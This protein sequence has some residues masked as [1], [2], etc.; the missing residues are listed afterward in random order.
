MSQFGFVDAKSLL[1]ALLCIWSESGVTSWSSHRSVSKIP[2][3]VKLME[4]NVAIRFSF[5]L[6]KRVGRSLEQNVLRVRCGETWQSSLWGN[7]LSK[8]CQQRFS[9]ENTK[10]NTVQPRN[11]CCSMRNKV[12]FSEILLLCWEMTW[13]V[14]NVST[15]CGIPESSTVI[16]GESVRLRCSS[17][18]MWPQQTA[19]VQN[20]FIMNYLYKYLCLFLQRHLSMM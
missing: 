12:K 20:D 4:V 19:L 13:D 10:K 9:Y 7:T 1:R 17:S 5:V 16:R 18:E 3:A 2:S 14:F 11:C 8:G 6:F 15:I